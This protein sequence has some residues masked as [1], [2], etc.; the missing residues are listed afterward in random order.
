MRLSP[1]IATL[2]LGLTP[3]C[4]PGDDDDSGAEPTPDAAEVEVT[5]TALRPASEEGRGFSARDGRD[6][7]IDF[8]SV[9][10]PR[11]DAQSR[12]V[13][14]ADLD[15]DGD[16]D[17][18]VPVAYE[19]DE[20]EQFEVM[21]YGGDG[22]GGFALAAGPIPAGDPQALGLLDYDED[23]LV[24]VLSVGEELSVL[25]NAGGL[26]LEPWQE[27]WTSDEA[28]MVHASA[29]DLDGDGRLDLALAGHQAFGT[30]PEEA[31]GA[32][33]PLLLR[34]GDG[35]VELLP[36]TAPEG[37][38]QI[39][40]IGDFDW[41]GTVEFLEGNEDRI[42]AGP[43]SRLWR[44]DGEGG[45]SPEELPT[46]SLSPMGE[47]GT[48]IDA[49]G[50]PEML[51]TDIGRLVAVEWTELGAVDVSAAL[52]G[53]DV[54]ELMG[55][56][57]AGRLVGWSVMR[58]S[59]GC[60]F[61]VMGPLLDGTIQEAE[62]APEQPSQLFCAED[63]VLRH[64]PGAVE[65]AP[66]GADDGRAGAVGDL[67]GDGLADVVVRN[68]DGPVIV[69]LQRRPP[70]CTPLVVRLRWPGHPNAD[71]IGAFVE[72]SGERLEVRYDPGTSHSA[73]D[74]ALYLCGAEGEEVELRIDWPDGAVSTITASAGTRVEVARLF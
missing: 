33:N 41:D 65:P 12:G 63:G 35:L 27:L 43:I 51:F 64:V 5:A 24:D 53:A 11:A 2:L 58:T 32:P 20:V 4:G 69:H 46:G 67:D 70:G 44:P 15:G 72:A 52:I 66:A 31:I 8:I 57:A 74:P 68:F 42:G 3:G 30:A 22:A 19:H 18:V 39:S 10:G 6:L 48:D 34:E 21:V 47:I 71:A 50:Q 16:L 62:T 49:D 60:W 73:T 26:Q 7:G 40:P 59:P 55:E 25:R 29:G 17:L 1:L 45:W 23:G 56:S 14:L 28:L 9:P 13:A 36:G 37:I 61:V 38:S 54:N